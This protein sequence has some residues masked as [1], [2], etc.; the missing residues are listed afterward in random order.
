M[1]KCQNQIPIIKTSHT[2]EIILAMSP[3]DKRGDA[4]L[5]TLGPEN[6]A[7][8]PSL[9]PD[10]ILWLDVPPDRLRPPLPPFPRTPSPRAIPR[11]WTFRRAVAPSVQPQICAVMESDLPPPFAQSPPH[12]P[13]QGPEGSPSHAPP[14]VDL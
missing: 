1:R 8:F 3:R 12:T 11:V 14:S 5:S 4:R 2:G 13:P 6:S 7:S 9:T 10:Q